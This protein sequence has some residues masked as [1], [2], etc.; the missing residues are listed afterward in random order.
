MDTLV[1]HRVPWT[2]EFASL[3]GF[4]FLYDDRYIAM[5]AA[6]NNIYAIVD[7][8]TTGLDKEADEVIE[9]GVVLFGRSP[10]HPSVLEILAVGNWMN[11]PS[12][13][14]TEE[15]TRITGITQADVAGKKLPLDEI[16]WFLGTATQFIAHNADFDRKFYARLFPEDS[17]RWSCTSK[18]GEVDWQAK[19][20]NTSGLEL[21]MFKNGF[22][23]DAHRAVIDC[24]ATLQ[25]L[26]CHVDVLDA[27][28]QSANTT[29][30]IIRAVG[31]PFSVKDTLK[32]E[33]YRWN[34]DK[35]VWWKQVNT[36]AERQI[37]LERLEALYGGARYAGVDEI[38]RHRKYL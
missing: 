33:G 10:Q 5:Q 1:L 7:F 34:G 36:D 23:Y 38:P 14:I 12:K 2:K 11:E 22:F 29:G 19:G 35:K 8:E 26:I 16:K 20:F 25:L 18:G 4:Q 28:D 31:S 9:M 37:E 3:E 21:L 30:Y 32:S 15:I 27:I 6:A 13:P 17:R 24:I